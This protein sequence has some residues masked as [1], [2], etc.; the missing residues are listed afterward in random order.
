M[1]AVQGTNPIKSK[2][3]KSL[4]GHVNKHKDDET[5]F[6]GGGS[7]PGNINGGIAKYSGGK[8]DLYKSG[9]NKDK[10][11]MSLTGVVVKPDEYRGMQTRLRI[12]LFTVKDVK[13]EV[14]KTEEEQ[15]AR[16]L[17]EMRKLGIDTS[18]LSVD[19]WEEA[20]NLHAQEDVAFRFHTFQSAPTKQFPKP[21][22]FENWDGRIE[23]YTE[24]G[25]DSEVEDYTGDSDVTEAPSEEAEE[26]DWS[27]LGEAADGGDV[28]AQNAIKEACE[29]AGIDCDNL[30]SWGEAAAALG[31]GSEEG[32]EESQD[33]GWV[34]Q[35]GDELSYKPKGPGK[36]SDCVVTKVTKNT[37]TLKRK[38]DNK[39]FTGVPYTSDPP[40]LD[41]KE[42]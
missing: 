33:E 1:P 8:I 34:P 28:D 23:S 24:N 38:S 37:L 21:R 39:M 31:A 6:G 19:D 20:L 18:S 17:N 5:D 26:Q 41:G 14:K 15:V 13:G 22:V 10:P 29:A 27:A 2:A 32:K 7:L 42:L 4:G 40:T 12:D 30:D 36:P 35:V 25:E 11:Y 3:L 16:A 9:P